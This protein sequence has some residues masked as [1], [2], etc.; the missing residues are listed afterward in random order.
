MKFAFARNSIAVE[1]MEYHTAKSVGAGLTS[2]SLQRYSENG[3]LCGYTVAYL[4]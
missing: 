4:D 1:V 3:M 2:Y